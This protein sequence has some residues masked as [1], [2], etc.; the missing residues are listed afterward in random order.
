MANNIES[1]LPAT[2]VSIFTEMS[3]LANQYNAINLSQGFPE[4]DT[5][6]PLKDYLKSYVQQGLNQY[7]PS[8]GMP[9]LLEQIRSLIEYHYAAQVSTSSITVTSGATEALW[10][11][12]QTLVRAGDEVIVFDP[13]YDSYEPAINLAGGSCIHI[14]LTK[15]DYSI[16]WQ[17]VES[18][19]T[20]HTRAIIINSPHNP[21]GT[22]LSTDDLQQLTRLANKYDFYVI[23]DEVYEFIT[24]DQHQH[25]SVLKYPDLFKRSFVVSSFGK[26]F[27]ATGWKLGYCVAPEALSDEFRKIHQYVTFSSFT[28]AQLAV[29]SMLENEPQHVLGLKSFYQQKRDLLVESLQGSRFQILPCLGTYFL[30]VDYSE[31]SEL[32]DKDFCYWLTKT[33]KVAAIPLSPFCENQ[34]GS[35]IIR[36]CFAKNNDTIKEAAHRLCQLSK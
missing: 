14:P 31:L 26:T 4:F 23:S 25:E 16:D 22:L 20:Q 27:H 6:G 1:K 8:I 36:L 18:R 2:G 5:P 28:P 17:V 34:S 33:V 9:Q 15:K 3:Q 30:L 10:V 13:A 24:F 11:A 35:K 7:A 12:I 29:A 21:T 32:S 19:I